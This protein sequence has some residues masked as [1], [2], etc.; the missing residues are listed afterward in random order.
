MYEE[1]IDV[2]LLWDWFFIPSARIYRYVP[3]A[4]THARMMQ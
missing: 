2:I 3:Y 1:M 4:R